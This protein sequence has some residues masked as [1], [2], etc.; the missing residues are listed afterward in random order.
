MESLYVVE[1]L[2]LRAVAPRRAVRGGPVVAR[3]ARS[4]RADLSLDSYCPPDREGVTLRRYDAATNHHRA[5]PK[6]TFMGCSSRWCCPDNERSVWCL[7]SGID[8]PRR[9]SNACGVWRS[10]HGI[11]LAPCGHHDGKHDYR[12]R[13]FCQFHLLRLVA[14]T[15]AGSVRLLRDT[16]A[17]GL[18][19]CRSPCHNTHCQH[20]EL[21]G[22]S[23]VPN[24]SCTLVAITNQTPTAVKR[25]SL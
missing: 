6:D 11:H 8:L 13:P 4:A 14:T 12:W 5:G 24:E 20:I 19:G 21:T 7:D 23:F 22:C 1:R 18:C 16:R 17:F 15:Q 10:P 2:A 3:A 9:I 25:L